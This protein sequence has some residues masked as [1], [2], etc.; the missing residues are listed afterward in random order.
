MKFHQ[1]CNFGPKVKKIAIDPNEV[2]KIFNL[3]ILSVFSVSADGNSNMCAPR[4]FL[5]QI[6]LKCPHFQPVEY[7]KSTKPFIVLQHCLTQNH[8]LELSSL[9][10][11]K[12]LHLAINE[13]T[14]EYTR[15]KTIV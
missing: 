9:Y 12:S 15:K 2:I 8:S 6:K 10:R 11:L 13:L 4:A 14:G 3:A 1:N 7:S 5:G